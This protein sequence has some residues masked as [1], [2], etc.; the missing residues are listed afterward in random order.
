MAVFGQNGTAVEW[1][2]GHEAV[3]IE[4]WGPDSLRVRGTLWHA[5]RD[6]LPGALLSSPPDSGSGV[7]TDI[8]ADRT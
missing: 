3:R 4:P 1:R 2:R 8:T 6:D 7:R 5:V